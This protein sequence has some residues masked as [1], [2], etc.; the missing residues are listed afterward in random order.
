MKNNAK[1]HAKL[2]KSTT[3]SFNETYF[4]PPFNHTENFSVAF[5]KH[6]W[7]P[8]EQA[9]DIIFPRN[10]LI[11]INQKHLYKMKKLDQNRI[12]TDLLTVFVNYSSITNSVNIRGLFKYECK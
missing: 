11:K 12:K 1:R 10:N 5:L 3:S 7:S 8:F 4:A 2:Y 6:S 9:N